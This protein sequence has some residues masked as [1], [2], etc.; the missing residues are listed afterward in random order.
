MVFI[1]QALS[2]FNVLKLNEKARPLLKGECDF[3][4]TPLRKQ[5]HQKKASGRKEKSSQATDSALLTL[6]K[7]VRTQLAK[8]QD[9]PPFMIFSDASLVDMANRQ[10]TDNDQ[11]LEIH[12]VG[13]FK[14]KKYGKIYLETIAN[15]H[16]FQDEYD[17]E[18]NIEEE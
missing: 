4:A 12:G 6:L 18:Q 15:Y 14:L 11:F 8:K 1:R 5:L 9:V 17:N 10:P 2:E 16:E 7:S 3:K 13:K